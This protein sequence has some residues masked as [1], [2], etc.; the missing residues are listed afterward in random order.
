MTY[1]FALERS[2]KTKAEWSLDQLSRA[3][4]TTVVIEN[5]RLLSYAPNLP[6]TRHST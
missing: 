5:D 1:P 4:D 3:A 6:M 2:R